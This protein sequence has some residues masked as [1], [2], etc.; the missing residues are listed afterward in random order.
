HAVLRNIIEHIFGI[1]KHQ[2][3][4]LNIPLEYSMDIQVRIPVAL[5][6]LHNFINHFDIEAFDDPDFDWSVLRFDEQQDEVPVGNGDQEE[7]VQEGNET[8][9][10]NL[11]QNAISQAMW[12][13]YTLECGRRGIPLP[14]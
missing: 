8:T 2:W 5:S 14:M 13:D 3:R 7:F 1:I 9:W 11:W 4:V 12:V 6:A 10:A